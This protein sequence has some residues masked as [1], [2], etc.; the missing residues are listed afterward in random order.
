LGYTTFAYSPIRLDRP[1]VKTGGRLVAE[2]T[3]TNTGAREGVET[4]FWFIRDP[5]A[6]LTRPLKELKHFEQAA[7]A[8][9]A[10][11]VFRCEIEPMRDL[12]FPDADGRRILEPGEIILMA[13]HQQTSFHVGH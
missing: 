9:G 1:E 11:R 3:V 8:P 7:L 4:V 10:S 5:A 13:G 6:S 2:V 12:S